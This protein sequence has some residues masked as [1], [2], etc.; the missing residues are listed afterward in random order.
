L[1]AALLG[2]RYHRRNSWSAAAGGYCLQ[3]L[4]KETQMAKKTLQD[5]LRK[6][7][8]DQDFARQ[9][10]TDPAQFKA[11]Y[12]LTDEQMAQIS[13]AGQAAQKAAGGSHA[14]YEDGGGGGGDG[15]GNPVV[16]VQMA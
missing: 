11:E 10:V 9:L 1:A 8:A 16:P 13:G 14:Q 4:K 2:L 3:L 6:A 12:E 5:A 15:G 7:A